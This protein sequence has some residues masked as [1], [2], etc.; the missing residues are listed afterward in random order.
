[1]K[2]LFYFGHPA[3]YLFLRETIR[4]LSLS[5][6]NQIIILIKT[7]DVLEELVKADGFPYTNIL[8]KQR[9]ISKL[10]VVL[11]FLNR[12]RILIPI[13]FR[14][15][16]DLLIGTDAT[17]AQLG[18][19]FGINRITIVEDDYDVIRNLANLTYPVTQTILCPDV[20]QVGPWTAKKIGY[21]G[22][23]KLGYL[24]PAVFTPDPGI[25][26]KYDLPKQ[27]V[28]IRLARLTA[29]HDF[30][31]HGIDVD[32]LQEVIELIE[33]AGVGV[34]I[35]AEATIDPRFT[36]FLLKIDPSDLHHVL[37]QATLLLSDS[38][39]MSVEAAMLGVPSI[40]YSDLVGRISV[41]EELEHVYSLTFGIH[42][43]HKRQLLDCLTDLLQT[44]DRKA[45]FKTRR[46]RMLADKL[47][48]TAFLVWF[49]EQYPISLD[50]MKGN[51]A[52][53]DRF[54]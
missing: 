29:H 42:T 22:Y 16:P 11:S 10:S 17:I 28:L 21:K 35:T 6:D 46:E 25:S 54:L 34:K 44:P 13:I 32:L 19:L 18:K 8:T 37:A 2:Y 47:D 30:G 14:K 1:M 36:H 45:T 23:M 12:I 31:I 5:A 7:K 41:L 48:V 33:A 26:Q 52:Y 43:G 27:Y 51:P 20:C 4:R 24:H 53:Q 38:Q 49:L 3:Q 39:S 15:K 50:K 9:G 40:R